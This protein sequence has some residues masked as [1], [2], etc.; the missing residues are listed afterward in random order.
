MMQWWR[1]LVTKIVNPKM[2]AANEPEPQKPGDAPLPDSLDRIPP[3]ST[4]TE[5]PAV[6]NAADSANPVQPGDAAVD[7]PPEYSASD[8]DALGQANA[9]TSPQTQTQNDRGQLKW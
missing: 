8:P 3:W 7:D 4:N 5:L 2:T 6:E 9:S 1:F